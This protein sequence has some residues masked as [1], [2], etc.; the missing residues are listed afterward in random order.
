MKKTL[1]DVYYLKKN[2]TPICENMSEM[3]NHYLELIKKT[4]KNNIKSK[5]NTNR[6]I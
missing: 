4:K 1:K 5:T 3:C 2:F 6:K